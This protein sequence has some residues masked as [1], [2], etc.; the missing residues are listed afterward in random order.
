VAGERTDNKLRRS[1][2]VLAGWA[3]VFAWVGCENGVGRFGV[4]MDLNA[5]LRLQVFLP[6]VAAELNGVTVA[7]IAV[8]GRPT[9]DGTSD[10]SSHD[11]GRAES[12]VGP[13]PAATA[14][15]G[16][17]W[18]GRTFVIVCRTVVRGAGLRDAG[19]GLGKSLLGVRNLELEVAETSATDPLDE[20]KLI[21]DL[22]ESLVPLVVFVRDND[23]GGALALEPVGNALADKFVWNK[24]NNHTDRKGEETEYYGVSPLSAVE[25]GYTESHATDEDDQSLTAN[26]D[27][28]DNDEEPVVC[29]TLKDV[30]AVVEA[31]IVVR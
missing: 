26:H 24:T 20:S 3:A 17:R 27:C 10:N 7:A 16:C 13:G 2:H 1:L 5:I 28:Q 19:A 14:T 23:L 11:S 18:R 31:A 6:R 15:V 30:E 4:R 29:D 21:A 22:E 9:G 8:N 12:R 25:P